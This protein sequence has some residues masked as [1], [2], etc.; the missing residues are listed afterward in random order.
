MGQS[1]EKGIAFGHTESTMSKG[2]GQAGLGNAGQGAVAV[3][4]PRLIR[5]HLLVVGLTE[6]MG[7][8]RIKLEKG[9]GTK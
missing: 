4:S 1:R 5:T 2:R 8:C 7:D 9:A 3:L 6:T